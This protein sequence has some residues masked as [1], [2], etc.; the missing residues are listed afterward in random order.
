MVVPRHLIGDKAVIEFCS[1]DKNHV[2]IFQKDKER[3]KEANIM[4]RP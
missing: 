2:S 3:K 4:F 1:S